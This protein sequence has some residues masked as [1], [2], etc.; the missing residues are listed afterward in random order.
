MLYLHNGI[1]FNVK[2]KIRRNGKTGRKLKCILLSQHQPEKMVCVCI[3]MYTQ[4]VKC[5]TFWKRQLYGN[6]KKISNCQGF[7]GKERGLIDGAQRIFKA[8]KLLSMV[9]SQWVQVIICLSD[10]LEC[11]TPRVNSKLN[12]KL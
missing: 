3:L 9:S 11:I 7:V 5:L 1:L 12:H 8:V 10:P 2:N 6:S 4:N